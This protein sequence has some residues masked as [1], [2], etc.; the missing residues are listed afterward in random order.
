MIFKK[1]VSKILTHSAS[2]KRPS[3][4]LKRRDAEDAAM[5]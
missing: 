3:S 4:D 1:V 5:I 2:I